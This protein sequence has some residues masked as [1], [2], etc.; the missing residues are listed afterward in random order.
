MGIN[1]V[2]IN[3]LMIMKKI[4]L[5][6]ALL[7]TLSSC[8]GFSCSGSYTNFEVKSIAIKPC[9]KLE[10]DKYILCSSCCKEL[11]VLGYKFS[12]ANREDEF[13]ESVERIVKDPIFVNGNFYTCKDNVLVDGQVDQTKLDSIITVTNRIFQNVE[14]IDYT[15]E[16][17]SGSSSNTGGSGMGIANPANTLSPISPLNPSS[18]VSVHR[19]YGRY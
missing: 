18:P 7:M 10:G 8:G 11:C 9:N 2:T 16:S 15:I 1:V 4:L 14:G 13:Y 19:S 17:A 5:L 12:R 6:M 3:K